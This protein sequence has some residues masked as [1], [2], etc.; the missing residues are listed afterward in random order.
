MSRQLVALGSVVCCLV[1]SIGLLQGYGM[2][3]MFKTSISLAVA[4]VPEGLLTV[5]TTILA[6]GIHTM[7]R[8]HVLIRHLDAVETLGAVQTIC[9]DKT[10]TI[11]RNQMTVTTVHSGGRGFEVR[12]GDFC[13]DGQRLNP[14]ACH[15]LLRLL[16]VAV[17]CNETDMVQQHGEYVLRGSSLTSML[18][19][20]FDFRLAGII[21]QFKL[22][23]LPGVVKGG[24]YQKLAT[25]G[26]M[27]RRD[28]G[29]PWEV[30]DK[31]AIL[32]EH[33]ASL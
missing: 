11:T 4:T 10:G 15:E 5:A 31:I 28:I 32:Q 3:E 27:G 19:Q 30:T 1:F 21:R 26:H 25:Y 17:L 33:A 13:I 8:Q 9:L 20:H 2:L 7:R 14:Y 29:L 22:R 18:Q 24:F 12:D 23:R 6:L 16:H